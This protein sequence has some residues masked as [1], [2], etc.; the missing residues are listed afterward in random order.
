MVH[1]NKKQ[2]EAFPHFMGYSCCF[3]NTFLY[4]A[5]FVRRNLTQPALHF[6]YIS[7]LSPVVIDETSFQDD[8]SLI[9]GK[10]THM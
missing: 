4:I 3:R 10:L 7:S 9:I 1:K 5:V 8:L 6:G 2:Q